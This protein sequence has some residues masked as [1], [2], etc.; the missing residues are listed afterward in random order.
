[1][2][3]LKKALMAG[4]VVAVSGS[5]LYAAPDTA[6]TEGAATAELGIAG[7]DEA[8]KPAKFSPEEVIKKSNELQIQMDQDMV[9]VSRLQQKARKDKDVIKLNCVN[10][11]MV[12]MKATMN[13]AD[14]KRSQL[15]DALTLS[16]GRGPQAFSDYTKNAGDIKKLREEADVCVGVGVDS[17]IDSKLNISNPAIPDDPTAGDP[18]DDGMEPPA[19]A[20]PYS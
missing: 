2:K 4:L 7:T 1:M 3:S 9:H 16:N 11:K 12:Q 19:Y 10:D 14:D 15:T 8:K 20:S 6:P 17:A 13:L 5:L 18:F